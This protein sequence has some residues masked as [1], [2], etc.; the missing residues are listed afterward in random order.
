MQVAAQ[1]PP[2]F[3]ACGDEIG[4]RAL[5][6]QRRL[7]GMSG[8]ADLSGQVGEQLSVHRFERTTGRA[9]RDQ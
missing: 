1:S 3:F 4:A 7:N 2:L 6:G 8:D 5:Q 9:G